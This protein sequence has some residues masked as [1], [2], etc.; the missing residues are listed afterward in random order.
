MDLAPPG[1]RNERHLARGAGLERG[2]AARVA[3]LL[4]AGAVPNAPA[5]GVL[6]L[7]LAAETVLTAAVEIVLLGELHELYGRVPHGDARERAAAYLAAT[8]V[9]GLG[10]AAAGYALSR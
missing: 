3:E 8:L 10:A 7:E 5:Y 1:E 4:H 9:L 2:E 6:P